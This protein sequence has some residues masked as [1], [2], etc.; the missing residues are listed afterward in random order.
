MKLS[1]STCFCFLVFSISA[2][3]ADIYVDCEGCSPGEYAQVAVRAAPNGGD[4]TVTNVQDGDIVKYDVSWVNFRSGE[5]Q[6]F[7]IPVKVDR[8]DVRY[9]K[10]ISRK[11]DVY[12]DPSI[13]A[14]GPGWLGESELF[15]FGATLACEN[16]D[17]CYE[18]GGSRA[19]RRACDEE[20]RRNIISETGNVSLA[21]KFFTLV[22]IGGRFHFNYT[23]AGL[24]VPYNNTL[25]GNCAFLQ[26]CQ[27]YNDEMYWQY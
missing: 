25:F 15:D 22:R 8:S 3:A 12:A 18:I 1:L 19:D 23:N 9:F 11:Y 27:Y 14:C 17:L 16:H 7:A 20:L 2:S 13:E 4:V 26:V 10:D 24:S 21:R 6:F 5:T